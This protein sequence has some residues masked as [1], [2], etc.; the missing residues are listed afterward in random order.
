VLLP[1]A[2]PR[3][4]EMLE[5]QHI[6][7]RL[8][9]RARDTGRKYE[10]PLLVLFA[11]VAVVLLI[12]CANIANLILARNAARHHEIV[13]RLVSAPAC[14]GCVATVHENLTLSLSGAFVGLLLSV[15][16][17]RVLVSLLPSSP[18]P[19]AFNLQRI[20]SY[21]A[22]QPGLPSRLRYC[23]DLARHTCF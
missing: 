18:L 12:S 8:P 20:M 14:A 10:K 7:V 5:A 13:V 16:G 6:T 11:V 4:K 19:M 1:S 17:T 21:L 22:F 15:W 9:P 3:F 23:S 2:S